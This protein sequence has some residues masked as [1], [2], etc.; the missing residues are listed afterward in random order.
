MTRTTTALLACAA[1]ALAACDRGAA[2]SA[3]AGP[4]P[5]LAKLAPETEPARA[6]AP[7]NDSTRATAGETLSV[8]IVTRLPDAGAADRGV[9]S[10]TEVLTLRA[11]NGV[12][13]EAELSGTADPSMLVE[14]RTLR[15]LMTLGVD[16]TQTLVYRVT[17]AQGALCEDGAPSHIVMWEPN[18]P[19]EIALKILPLTGAAPGQASAHACGALDFRRA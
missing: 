10:T 4:G 5:E 15:A 19:A 6:F 12:S 9:S 14:G 11:G 1:L 8:S 18:A 16:A 13:V 7:A 17:R 2:V 3:S